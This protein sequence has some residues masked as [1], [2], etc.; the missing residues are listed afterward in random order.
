MVDTISSLK[1]LLWA[2]KTYSH[3]K[4]AFLAS[5]FDSTLFLTLISGSLQIYEI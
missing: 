5:L 1:R 4:N 3:S 2:E